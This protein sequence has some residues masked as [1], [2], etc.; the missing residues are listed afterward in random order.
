MYAGARLS[1]KMMSSM[2]V[3]IVS[4]FCATIVLNGKIT[5]VI[6]FAPT[7]MKTRKEARHEVR[8]QQ[9]AGR[10]LRTRKF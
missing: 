3:P 1:Q 4:V 9:S 8:R 7:V 10:F 2:N 6:L 5:A